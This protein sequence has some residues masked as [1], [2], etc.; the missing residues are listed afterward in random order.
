M[1]HVGIQQFDP[2]NELHQ[3]LADIS[4]KCHQLNSE[5]K[6]EEIEKF[7]KDMTSW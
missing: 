1:Q 3:K 7:E 5:G 2:K 4:R 6:V